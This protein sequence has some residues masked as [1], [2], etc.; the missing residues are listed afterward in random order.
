QHGDQTQRP[1]DLGVVGGQAERPQRGRGANDHG[2]GGRHGSGPGVQDQQPHR[3]P[4]SRSKR[5]PGAQVSSADRNAATRARC[6]S[7]GMARKV[8][9]AVSAAGSG[10][11]RPAGTVPANHSVATN[12]ATKYRSTPASSTRLT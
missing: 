1:A 2:E 7:N 5:S 11:E 6:S 3:G 8:F 9:S 10:L 12:R 4:I